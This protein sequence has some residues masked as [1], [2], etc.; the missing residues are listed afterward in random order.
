MTDGS[1]FRKL[2]RELKRRKVLRVASVYAIVCFVLWQVGD[3]V[4][5]PLGLPP[6]T[7]TLLIVLTLFGFPITLVLAWAYDVTPEGVRRT[8]AASGEARGAAESGADGAAPPASSGSPRRL[9]LVGVATGFLLAVVGLGIVTWALD[10]GDRGGRPATSAPS[11][12][13]TARIVAV[14]PFRVSGSGVEEWREG[15]A[16]LL[17]TALDGAGGIRALDTRAVLA[18]WERTVADAEAPE[19]RAAIEVARQLGAGYTLLGSA[20]ALGPETRFVVDVWRTD[21]ERRLGQAQVQGPP[22]SV[23]AL[24]D[25]LAREVLGLLLERSGERIP[26]VDLASLTTRSIPAL[27]AY[28]EGESHFRRGEFEEAIDAY[29]EAVRRDTT[30]AFAHWRLHF[31]YGWT[32]GTISLGSGPRA[33]RHLD[34]AMELASRLPERERRLVRANHLFGRRGRTLAAADTLR[35]L[36]ER[37]PDDPDAHYL[38]GELLFHHEVPRGPPEADRAFARAVELDSAFAQYHVHRVH[39]AFNFQ[40]DSALALERVR[41]HPGL[42]ATDP[43]FRIPFALAFG[44]PAEREMALLALDTLSLPELH[45]LRHFLRHPADAD[46]REAVE[47]RA[48]RSLDA[49]FTPMDPRRVLLTMLRRGRLRQVSAQL[50]ALKE[51][52]LVNWPCLL[53]RARWMGMPVPEVDPSRYVPEAVSAAPSDVDVLDVVCAAFYAMEEE[54]F[55]DAEAALSQ[56]REMARELDQSSP[57]RAG[58]SFEEGLALMEATFEGYRAWKLGEP[59]SAL[60]ILADTPFWRLGPLVMG[61]LHREAG[62]LRTAE[63]WYLGAWSWPVA[64]ERLGELYEELGEPERAAAAYGRFVAGWEDADPELQGRVEAARRRMAALEKDRDSEGS[65]GARR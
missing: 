56:L 48:E 39:L 23:L 49:S 58:P 13:E 30:F 64:H 11:P 36:T 59:Q 40:R 52:G 7:M 8:E 18:R 42:A 2:L 63:G 45:D 55:R 61:D 50:E 37:Y 25:A 3:L 22:D 31:A 26:S 35:R 32:E 41:A 12:D 1:P 6:W 17:Q 9:L 38:L 47:L 54:R 28:L 14:L 51:G 16:N 20:L 21:S 4:F 43:E 57:D 33:D 19:H 34:R 60:A 46:L 27:K 44:A 15:M 5:E 65:S 29:T 53:I 62:D 24:G 10:S